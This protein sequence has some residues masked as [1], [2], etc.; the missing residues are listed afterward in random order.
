[1]EQVLYLAKKAG[2]LK[3]GTTQVLKS[4][5]KTK[6]IIIAFDYSSKDKFIRI[7]QKLNK[8]Y[9]VLNKSKKE[10][11]ELFKRYEVGILSINDENLSKLFLT[12]KEVDV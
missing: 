6:L 4:I 7:A 5:K 2:K 3:I 1:M 10:L 8:N 12:K 11:G 9:V